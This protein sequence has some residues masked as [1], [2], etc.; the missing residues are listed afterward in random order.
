MKGEFLVGENL[1]VGE[2]DA[3]SPRAMMSAWLR[4]PQHRRALLIP[5]F[6]EIGVALVRGAYQDWDSTQ[7][8]VAHLG[9]RH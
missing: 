5:A 7:I 6:D 8:W 1:A 4:S 9:Y 3:G 2:G